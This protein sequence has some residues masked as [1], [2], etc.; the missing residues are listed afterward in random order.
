MTSTGPLV[1]LLAVAVAVTAATGVLTFRRRRD[2][3]AALPLTV[4]LASV[5]LWGLAVVL[6]NSGVPRPWLDALVLPQFLGIG[7][8]VLSLRLFVDAVSGR[9]TTARRVLAL[10]VEPVLLV[11]VVALDP[12]LHWFHAT[13]EHVGDPER[14]VVTA[15]PLFWVHTAYSYMVVLSAASTVHRLRRQTRGLLRRQATT[16]LVAIAA[17]FAANLGVV[18]LGDVV[19]VDVTPLAF[20]VTGVLFAY[21]V[22]QQDLLRLVPVARSLVVETVTDAVFVVDARERVVDVNPAG[23]A[24][25]RREGRPGGEVIGRAFAGSVEPA[26]ARAVGDGDGDAV[27]ALRGGTHLDV[28]TRWIRDDRGRVLG[29]V[30]VARDVTEQLGAARALERANARLREQVATIEHLRAELAEE[31]ARD[32]LT[33]LRNRRRFVDDLADRLTAAAATG[34]P[35]SL[36]L[37]DVDH[38]KAVNDT[39]GHAIGDEVLVAVARALSAHARAEDVVRYGGE[40]FVVLLPHLDAAAA[41]RRAEELRAACARVRV[42]VE[43]LRV[44]V[45]AGVATAPDHGS[46][47]DELLLAADRALY[48]A[49]GGGRDRVALAD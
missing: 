36:V 37:L 2:T 7:A 28:R 24:L 12:Q 29:R 5:T 16:M 42:E 10:T 27:V 45:S 11:V 8:T 15:G 44:T 13:V 6:L 9:T 39:H 23:T 31:A 34:Q 19:E 32:P 30:V 48:E 38:F 17:P 4:A 14:R 43:D 33:G 35:L 1:L 18:F 49:K 21:A 20:T 40:E 25:V 46:T 47:P 41:H 26:L 22:L 3:P